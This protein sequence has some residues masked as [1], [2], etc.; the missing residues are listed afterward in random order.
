MIVPG[1]VTLEPRL[2]EVSGFVPQQADVEWKVVAEDGGWRLD[3][4][5]LVARSDPARRAGRDRS[6]RALGR[7]PSTVPRRRRVRGLAAR[8]TRARRSAVRGPGR[9]RRGRAGATR[10]RIGHASRRRLRA[11]CPDVGAQRADLGCVGALGRDGAVRRPLGGRRR[12]ADRSDRRHQRWAGRRVAGPA[13]LPA[14]T[15]STT[16]D[17]SGPPK[18]G[19]FHVQPSS[20]PPGAPGPGHLRRRRRR[21]DRH[22]GG[23]QPPRGSAVVARP[24]DRPHRRLRVRQPRRSRHGDADRQRD[25]VRAARRRPELLPVRRRRAV[26]AQRRQRRRRAC[27]QAVPV[28]VHDDDRQPRHVPLQ[29]EPGHELRRS[30][31]QRAPDLH[32]D[33]GRRARP[34]PGC[35][36]A[37]CRSRRPTSASARRRTTR[38]NLG[39]AA[40]KQVSGGISDLRRAA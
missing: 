4:D 37:T 19:D 7:R 11:R 10:R 34:Q 27:R 40:V 3:L 23:V 35:S 26:P 8:I 15:P 1:E 28:P 38:P 20:P 16:P 29:H 18:A 24:G 30:R 25:P 39:S 13:V 2:D 14:P 31:P 36:D 22:R 9:A 33:R 12:R 6:G 21:R 17:P 32:V 5:G